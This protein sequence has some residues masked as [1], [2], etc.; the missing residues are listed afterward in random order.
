MA[1]RE[2]RIRSA[3]WL[4]LGVLGI[5]LPASRT[6]AQAPRACP[7]GA[8]PVAAPY[9]VYRPAFEAPAKRPLFFSSYAGHNYGRGPRAAYAPAGYLLEYPRPV[10]DRRPLSRWFAR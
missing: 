9:T 5:A 7:P 8:A 2:R 3:T 1:A 6:L 4:V 10:G